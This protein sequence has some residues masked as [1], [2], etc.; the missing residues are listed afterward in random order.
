MK[1]YDEPA[2]RLP[3]LDEAD[4][5]VLGGGPGGV[6]AAISAARLGAR[7]IIVERFGS[8]GGTWT[9]GILS[10]IMP[11]PFVRGVFNEIIAGMQRRGGWDPHGESYGAAGNYD[12]EVAKVTLDELVTKAGAIPYFFTSVADVIRDGDR[13]RGVIVESKEGRQVILA[14][15]FID[16]SG[17]GD[18]CVRAGVP[19]EYGRE[20]DG[21]VQPMT[22]IFKMDG[23][24]TARAKAFKEQ[25]PSLE[26]TWRKAK[27]AGDVTVPRE[28]VLTSPNPKPGQWNFNT[29][30]IIGKDGTK[31][32]DVTEAMI[33]GR[34]Q[35][36]EVAAF[37]RKYVPGFEHAVVSETPAHVGVRETRRIHCDYTITAKDVIDVVPFED[38]ISRG[39]WF[40][41][42]HSP[43]GEGTERIH[44]PEG[45]WYEVP[46]RS[47]RAQG[48][49]NLLVA[50]RCIDCT[51]EAHAAIRI[52]PQVTAIGEAAGAAAAL[53]VKQ[54]LDSTRQLDAQQLRETLRAQG[55][56]V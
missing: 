20:T 18:V 56:L 37:M 23:V 54:G 28:D 46:Y 9:A 30:R 21:A 55:A 16:A 5:L 4:V 29:T 15:Y 7:T 49:E 35:V 25:D 31:V 43:T 45:K 53:C 1:F 26:R 48:I 2:H 10:A 14:K 22:M 19:F 8:F 32:K 3:V 41:D 11:F 17:D 12:S 38:A 27:E 42:I 40:I 47:L 24:D 51:H 36:A 52:T 34:R 50:S 13:L 6:G 44:P 39:N 33:E